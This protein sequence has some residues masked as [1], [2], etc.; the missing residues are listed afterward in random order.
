MRLPRTRLRITHLHTPRNTRQPR[1]PAHILTPYSALFHSYTHTD[2]PR[3]THPIPHQHNYQHRHPVCGSVCV[4]FCAWCSAVGRVVCV[5][6]GVCLCRSRCVEVCACLVG[7][8][9]CVCGGVCVCAWRCVSV[10]SV[11][12]CVSAEVCVLTLIGDSICLEF[13]W[14]CLQCVVSWN[15]FETTFKVSESLS[16][17]VQFCGTTW[18]PS[19][20]HFWEFS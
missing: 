14:P 19:W 20:D 4:E 7:L 13:C 10:W 6:R 11:W 3:N 5:S 2:T 12:R 9:V 17:H 15:H 1:S 8:E 18:K 16:D